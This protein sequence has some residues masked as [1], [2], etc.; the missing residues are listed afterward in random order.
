MTYCSVSHPVLLLVVKPVVFEF[1][2]CI[3]LSSLSWLMLICSNVMLNY[4]KKCSYVIL[5]Y[6]LVKYL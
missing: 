6:N 3:S 2:V 5:S 1:Y 4:H